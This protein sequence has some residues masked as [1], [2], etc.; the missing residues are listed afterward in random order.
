MKNF[1]KEEKIWFQENQIDEETLVKKGEE[2]AEK[3]EEK[4]DKE[5]EGKK[6]YFFKTSLIGER[7]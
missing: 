5:N 3:K 6:N 1:I 4:E 2:N 7:G